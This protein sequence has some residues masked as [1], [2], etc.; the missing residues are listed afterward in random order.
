MPTFP[1]H[2]NL[3]NQ[4]SVTSNATAAGSSTSASDM[5]LPAI[6]DLLGS[7]VKKRRFD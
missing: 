5:H 4:S 6:S 2:R 7:L 3:M 1:H